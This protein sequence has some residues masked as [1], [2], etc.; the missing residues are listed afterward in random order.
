M[1]LI[2]DDEILLCELVSDMLSIKYKTHMAYSV[3]SVLKLNVDDID[4]I[5]SDDNIGTQSSSDVY[6]IFKDTNIPIILM[7]GNLNKQV[8]NTK[9]VDCLY[10]P[11]DV[12]T[13]LTTIRKHI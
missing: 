9:F 12:A 2:I 7:T 6:E 1:I 10:K 11:F 13:L 4:L 8:D 3:E 5:L